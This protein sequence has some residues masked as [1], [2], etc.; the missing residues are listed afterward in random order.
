MD[1]IFHVHPNDEECPIQTETKTIWT[2]DGQHWSEID[3]VYQFIFLDTSS[4]KER[5][6][7][8]ERKRD[9]SQKH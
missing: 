7:E 5:E 4:S 9:H 2:K 1:I 3:M 8:R 6:R